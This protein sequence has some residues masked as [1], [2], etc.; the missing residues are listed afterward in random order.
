MFLKLKLQPYLIYLPILLIGYVFYTTVEVNSSLPIFTT[1][2][3]EISSFGIFTC[4]FLSLVLL[5]FISPQITLS[6]LLLVFLWY[7]LHINIFTN[8]ILPVIF[9]TI[10]SWISLKIAA[11]VTKEVSSD[12]FNWLP[13]ALF[14]VFALSIG[15]FL[16][17]ILLLLGILNSSIIIALISILGIITFSYFP[18]HTKL[19]LKFSD[20]FDSSNGN[21]SGA[22]FVQLIGILM[23][24]FFMYLFPDAV[25]GDS[26]KAYLAFV[27]FYAESNTL[28]LNDPGWLDNV[29]AGYHHTQEMFLSIGWALGGDTGTKIFALSLVISKFWM[30]FHLAR[31]I[32]NFST[33]TT[34]FALVCYGLIPTSLEINSVVRPENS[35][36][37]IAIALVLS[38]E[39]AHLNRSKV[40]K[41]NTINYSILIFL[42]TCIGFSIK[43][44]GA[45]L[46]LGSLLM[47]PLVWKK[48]IQ[49]L[50]FSSKGR[51]WGLISVLIGFS[52]IIR[53]LL[54]FGYVTNMPPFGQY[55][56]T[57]W[58]PPIRSFGE[59]WMMITESMIHVSRFTEFTDLGYGVFGYVFYPILFFSIFIPGIPRR[60]SGLTLI[61]IA[62]LFISTRQIRY[63]LPVIPFFILC[64]TFIFHKFYS[65]NKNRNVLALLIPTS[66][67]I[68]LILAK[69]VLT[70]STLFPLTV[71]RV[72]AIQNPTILTTGPV[73]VINSHTSEKDRIILPYIDLNYSMKAKM[74][75]GEPYDSLG[76]LEKVQ[77][78]AV[79]SHLMTQSYYT[80][81][82]NSPLFNDIDFLSLIAEPIVKTSSRINPDWWFLLFRLHPGALQSM[83][84][85]FKEINLDPYKIL[86]V[87]EQ[88]KNDRK[89]DLIS[90]TPIFLKNFWEPIYL[91]GA[92]WDNES[93]NYL[94][95]P[96][97]Y[98]PDILGWNF[99]DIGSQAG[100]P[101]SC[102]LE[103]K[104]S[105]ASPVICS[106]EIP[107]KTKASHIKMLL[108]QSLSLSSL[109]FP[110]DISIDKNLFPTTATLNKDWSIVFSQPVKGG[111]K[112]TFKAPNLKQF[113]INGPRFI[114]ESPAK[115]SINQ[116]Q[117]DDTV[118][119]PYKVQ[120]IN[121][122]RSNK[123]VRF[124]PLN[125]STDFIP[126]VHLRMYSAATFKVSGLVLQAEDT[127]KAEIISQ[128][129]ILASVKINGPKECKD[130][131]VLDSVPIES[132]IGSSSNIPLNFKITVTQMANKKSTIQK[133]NLELTVFHPRVPDPYD[134]LGETSA[135]PQCNQLLI[136]TGQKDFPISLV[137]GKVTK[138]DEK[139]EIIFEFN[140]PLKRNFIKILMR[141]P[142]KELILESPFITW[143]GNKIFP[144]ILPYK[145][146]QKRDYSELIFELSRSNE[147]KVK[148]ITIEKI[149]YSTSLSCILQ[150]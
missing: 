128:S 120:I 57:S 84:K 100:L 31:N 17:T 76:K 79:V 109:Q 54:R 63:L 95:Y 60:L 23:F 72:L 69:L 48:I 1:I 135:F 91:L 75:R 98:V 32:F 19:Q 40:E 7:T 124:N 105:E 61:Y 89:L 66:I 92:T 114:L 108:S 145:E 33:Q 90:S 28:L 106:I 80:K 37:L 107:G 111:D 101:G 21:F 138:L 83:V 34:L 126:P 51:V 117:R 53:N 78:T 22:F 49:D 110:F 130:E 24:S 68:Q 13:Y 132:M 16:A 67:I 44:T 3:N 119:L 123:Y 27:R 70:Q 12:E 47:Y 2:F 118:K 137:Q 65:E 94:R 25:A 43:Q 81:S 26:E 134:L 82:G 116:T 41:Q 14:P 104:N 122:E 38:L 39:V 127:L 58:F 45:Y 146:E 64:F 11:Y 133:G 59:L 143:R 55:H 71:D 139:N 20:I 141:V 93:K 131:C 56:L 148:S 15:A 35:L 46:A 29:M 129:K 103:L 50:I 142:T 6:S 73:S 62:L 113:G 99:L 150:N 115:K 74:F 149:P 87:S 5:S 125:L 88:Y 147:E 112:I 77:K 140:K 97:E 30:L 18:S 52:W 102:S 144:K 121:N 36:T 4:L 9:L 10:L 8:L 86:P 42:I 96:S 85:D 136:S